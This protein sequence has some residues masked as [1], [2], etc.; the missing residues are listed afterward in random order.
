MEIK[1]TLRN[2]TDNYISDE[3]GDALEHEITLQELTAAVYQMPNGKTPGIDGLPIEVY[4]EFWDKFGPLYHQAIIHAKNQGVLNIAA[5]RGVIAQIPKKDK[6]SLEIPN[7]RPLTM[8][9]CDYKILA[10][11]LALW[12]Q[13]ILPSIISEDQTGFMKGRNIATNIRKTIE[14]VNQA[15]KLNMPAL[16]IINGIRL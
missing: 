12:L 3:I 4:K 11:A 6:D 8:L 10:K 13:P 7:W 9:N 15:R 14:V 2:E 16:V 5:R 1:F